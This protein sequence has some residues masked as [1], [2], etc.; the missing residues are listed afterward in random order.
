MYQLVKMLKP[1]KR[2]YLYIGQI[3]TLVSVYQNV[4]HHLFFLDLIVLHCSEN[5]RILSWHCIAD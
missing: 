1:P 2:T 5:W 3:F 4:H